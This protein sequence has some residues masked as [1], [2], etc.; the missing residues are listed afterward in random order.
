MAVSPKKRSRKVERVEP[1]VTGNLEITGT[2]GST[3]ERKE[4][5]DPRYLR[6]AR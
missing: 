5:R 1:M 6:I 2:D 4:T 3:K